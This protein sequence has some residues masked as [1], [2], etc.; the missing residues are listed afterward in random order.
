MKQSCDRIVLNL[1]GVRMIDKSAL[2][3]L[4]LMRGLA[5]NIGIQ[6]LIINIDDDL[7]EYICRFSK[8]L[9]QCFSSEVEFKEMSR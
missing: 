8:E 4:N 9:E 2:E 1:L 3:M 7:R 6:L 5:V